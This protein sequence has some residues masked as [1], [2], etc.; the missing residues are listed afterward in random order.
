MEGHR[1]NV[2]HDVNKRLLVRGNAAQQEVT[3]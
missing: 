1:E 2:A 3:R